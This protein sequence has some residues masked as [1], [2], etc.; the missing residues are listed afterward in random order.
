MSDEIKSNSQYDEIIKGNSLLRRLNPIA[1]YDPGNCPV[2]AAAVHNYLNGKGI[3]PVR[4]QL[5]RGDYI[6]D[7]PEGKIKGVRQIVNDLRKKGHGHNVVVKAKYKERVHFMV[8]ANIRDKI[9]Y[10]DAYTI[11]PIVTEK[12]DSYLKWANE[13]R[14]YYKFAVRFVP[15]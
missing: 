3:R 10:L 9:Y 7:C 13:L 11:P 8:L 14:V 5:I 4:A 12:V 6:L 1:K 15:K 2:V